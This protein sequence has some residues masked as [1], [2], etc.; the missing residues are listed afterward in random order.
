MSLKGKIHD[1]RKNIE[2]WSREHGLDFFDTVFELVD[3]D[4]LNEIAAYGGFPTRYP[5]WRFGMEFD[6]LS[7]GYDYGFQKIYELVINTNPC[8]AYLMRSN[9]LV[10]QKI[11][12][13]HVFAHADFF[14]NNDWFKETN[15]KMID[16][17]GNHAAVVRSY[18]DRYGYETVEAFID[19]CLSIEGLIDVYHPYQ[20]GSE[21]LITKDMIGYLS[22]HAPLEDWQRDVLSMIR[23]EAYYFAPQGQTK[24][25]NEGW[26]T[27]WHLKILT[28]KA[29]KDAE[30]I[31]FADHHAA[32]VES[33]LGHMNPYRLGL[34]LFR[35]IEYRWDTGKFGKEFEECDDMNRRREWDQK[36]GRGREKIFEV[37]KHY[38]DLTFIDEF[39][40]PEFCERQKLFVYAY[41]KRN[42]AY[43]IFDRDFKK[44]KD[45][46]LFSLTHFGQPIICV[47]EGN[48]EGKGHLYLLHEHHGVD[49]KFPE[50]KEV[51]ERV[52]SLWKK[53]IHLETRINGE[54]RLLTYNGSEHLEKAI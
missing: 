14:K 34:E 32:V 54:K 28:E 37:R 50:A 11:V 12:I 43:E 29:L 10:D 8:Y 45:K 31:D 39:L 17:M 24:I 7:K 20:K 36:L 23:K 41:N 53:P 13:A 22:E 51:M 6:H 19:I 4:Q 5:H 47:L 38:N 16:M 42:G 25:L 52:F 3:A 27:Y 21:I 26:A 18:C 2:T 9:S 30:V 35:D 40:T 15:R 44:V 33:R 49:L 1:I 46:L 48:Y